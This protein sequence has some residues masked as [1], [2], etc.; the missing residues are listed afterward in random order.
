[1][2]STTQAAI[3]RHE[4]LT[5]SAAEL[6]ADPSYAAE[7]GV[8][9]GRLATPG[10][11]IRYMLGGHATITVVSLRTGTRY[12]FK[13]SAAPKKP[14]GTDPT[15]VPV[16]VSVLQ[17]TENESDYTYMACLF[18]AGAHVPAAGGRILRWTRGSKVNEYSPSALAFKWFWATLVWKDYMDSTREDTQLSALRLAERQESFAA[19][20]GRMEIW[21][22]GKCSR[23]GRKL[24]VP[25][26]IATGLGPVCATK[27]MH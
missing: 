23:C 1:M 14:N 8:M 7:A 27:Q 16:F 4:L 22:E 5:P 13:L 3:D 19:R 25:S 18:R 2:T 20:W 24:T 21:H 11:A 10:D 26:S 9:R 15:D 12:T 6:A 17:G